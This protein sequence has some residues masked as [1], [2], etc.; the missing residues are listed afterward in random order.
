MASYTD[1]TGSVPG[2]LS[3]S[4]SK[5]KVKPILKKLSHSEKNSLDLDRSWD[6]QPSFGNYSGS[7]GRER[8]GSFGGRDVSFSISATE[9]N[10]NGRSKFSHARSTSG[11]SHIS[12]ATSGSGHGHRNGSFVH[13][14]Q[15]TPRTLTPPLSYA[16]SFT[17]FDQASA[18]ASASASVAV[19][20]SSGPRDYSPTITEDDNDLLEQQYHAHRPSYHPTPSTNTIVTNP[21]SY[22]RRPSLASRTSSLSDIHTTGPPSLRL[23]TTRTNSNATSSRL[24]HVSSHSDINIPGRKSESAA[25]AP[26]TVPITSPLSTASPSTSV[27]AMSPL[28]TS[29]EGFRLRSRSE[30]DSYYHQERIREERRRWEEK[31]TAKEAKRAR[32]D[33]RKRERANTKDAERIMKEQQRLYQEHQNQKSSSRKKSFSNSAHSARNSSSDLIRP[34]VSRK[35]TAPDAEKLAMGELGFASRNYENTDEGEAPVADEGTFE[36]PRRSL[37]AKRKTQSAWTSFV[38]WFR[39]RVLRLNN[40]ATKR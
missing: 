7:L 10:S 31:E 4:R 25:I 39:T 33:M 34:S 36:G 15:Q 14:F 23:N 20:P 13:P 11:T 5:T 17:S 38:L 8:E 27:T 3:K 35:K 30:I 40:M 32:E 16:N 6:E 2:K 29:L 28:R 37:T 18:S 1:L 19:N 22:P 26:S 12:I 9:L 24:V 21:T